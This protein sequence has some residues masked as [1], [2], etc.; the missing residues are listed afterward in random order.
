MTSDLGNV[1][2]GIVFENTGEGIVGFNEE[3]TTIEWAIVIYIISFDNRN[4][5]LYFSFYSY[6]LRF[7]NTII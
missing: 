7:V 4:S 3:N 2:P 1:K 6:L 5:V